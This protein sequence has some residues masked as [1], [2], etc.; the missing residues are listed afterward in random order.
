MTVTAPAASSWLSAAVAT[1]KVAELA[2]ALM[3][4]CFIPTLPEATKSPF[5]PTF[6]L[7]VRPLASAAIAGLTLTVKLAAEPSVT[8]AFPPTAMLTT[9]SASPS[10]STMV[11][12]AEL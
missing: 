12:V 5:W 3:V 11:A 10:S 9:G 1:V 7:I 4:T 6:R 2:P 8:F